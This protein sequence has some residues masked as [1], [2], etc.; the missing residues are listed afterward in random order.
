MDENV[1]VS[2]NSLGGTTTQ[3]DQ[4]F[5]GVSNAAGVIAKIIDHANSAIGTRHC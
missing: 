2:T 3:A 1:V 5:N 4:S